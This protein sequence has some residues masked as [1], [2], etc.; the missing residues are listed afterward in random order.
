MTSAITTP[1]VKS[2]EMTAR[3]VDARIPL[4]ERIVGDLSGHWARILEARGML[5]RAESAAREAGASYTAQ[6]RV[7]EIV[8][9]LNRLVDRVNGCIQEVEQLGGTVQEY[10]RGVVTFPMR[11]NGRLVL[12]SWRRGEPQLAHWHE[13]HECFAY[14][15]SL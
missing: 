9:E 3:D 15:K 5:E 13:L 12:A 11:R 6:D 2:N 14:R 4:L 1:T 8:E 10:K 7:D